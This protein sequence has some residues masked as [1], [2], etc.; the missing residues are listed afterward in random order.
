MLSPLPVP[1]PGAQPLIPRLCCT[2]ALLGGMKRVAPARSGVAVWGVWN[3]TSG[4]PCPPARVPIARVSAGV[5]GQQ[6]STHLWLPAVGSVSSGTAAPTHERGCGTRGLMAE[7]PAMVIPP[8][9]ECPAPLPTHSPAALTTW[10]L[11]LSTCC[12][13]QPRRA[14]E[15][16]PGHPCSPPPLPED[17]EV[18]VGAVPVCPFLYSTRVCLSTVSVPA[19]LHPQGLCCSENTKQ[20]GVGPATACLSSLLPKPAPLPG[21]QDAADTSRGAGDASGAR[22]IAPAGRGG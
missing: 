1:C 21:A 6:G 19:S 10:S 5:V 20:F 2:Q 16:L 11:K 8:E 4:R 13:H 9:A 14:T 22:H 3:G 7:H 12:R 17:G 15:A 18:P